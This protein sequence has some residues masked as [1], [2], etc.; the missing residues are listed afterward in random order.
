MLTTKE[1]ELILDYATHDGTVTLTLEEVKKILNEIEQLRDENAQLLASEA[2][3][4]NTNSRLK[5][6][7]RRY[8]EADLEKSIKLNKLEDRTEALES[9]LNKIKFEKE[10][11]M[12]FTKES[13]V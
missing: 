6:E 1:K 10:Y 3:T 5:E 12:E 8:K 11:Y 13:G 7:I 9:E 4:Y 2:V